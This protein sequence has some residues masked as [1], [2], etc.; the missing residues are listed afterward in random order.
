[1]TETFAAL[2]FAH[3]L[4]DFA[5]QTGWMVA[6][7]REPAILL[8]HVAVVAVTAYAALG[9]IDTP[10]PLALAGAHLAIDAVKT[11]LVRDAGR[12]RPFLLD[13]AAHLATVAATAAL[14]PALWAGG[15]WAGLPWLAPVMAL[16]A[17]LIL[18][19]TAGGY[20]VGMLV[21][22]LLREGPQDGLPGG[23]RLIGL[24]ERGL[25]FVLI[26]VG[27]PAGIGFLIAAKSVL[28]YEATSQNRSASE[29]VI[30]GT[31]A[32]FGWA[33]LTGYAT[34]ALLRLLPGLPIP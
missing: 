24:L 14:A 30:V 22:P 11:Y 20:A 4:A 32:S 27:E 13:Q 6:R 3:V 15:I 28:R 7:K 2:I 33:M 18:A 9:R 10:L 31:L 12:L 21:Q 5:F 25:I 16:V 17:G 26:V 23:G 19:T 1:M 8:L 29:Y 34:T